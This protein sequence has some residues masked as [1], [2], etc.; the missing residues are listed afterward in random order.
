MGNTPSLEGEGK[1]K[2]IEEQKKIGKSLYNLDSKIEN[3][4]NQNRLLEQ[5]AQV[6]FQSWFVDFD[7]VTE[8]E[9]SELGKIPKGWSV[10]TIRNV[11][12]SISITHS[13]N[14]SNLLY[15][16]VGIIIFKI[17]IMF[18]LNRIYK[19]MTTIIRD[20]IPA[21]YDSVLNN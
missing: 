10:K 9:D 19:N 8:F 15:I 6:I 17:N 3:L 12:N 18:L 7:G 13:F 4:R 2:Y 20:S 5:T 1:D 14:K 16:F 11:C 21:K